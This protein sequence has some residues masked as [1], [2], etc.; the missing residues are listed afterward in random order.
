[1][2]I[3]IV[4]KGVPFFP[5]KYV[6]ICRPD[7]SS[8]QCGLTLPVR[9]IFTQPGENVGFGVE[10]TPGATALQP[11]P[12]RNDNHVVTFS[13]QQRQHYDR[14]CLSFQIGCSDDHD[15]TTNGHWR[16][17]TLFQRASSSTPT[18]RPDELC[19]TLSRFERFIHWT[20]SSVRSAWLGRI[21][22][23]HE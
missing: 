13:G 12:T 17:W 21:G 5:P 10:M 15:L 2:T 14:P 8:T 4:R 20:V 23:S 18:T 11:S 6:P 9:S 3:F 16:L 19:K 22:N 1:M 7:E